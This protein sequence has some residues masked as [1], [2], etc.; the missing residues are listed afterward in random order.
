MYIQLQLFN[1]GYLLT[2]FRDQKVECQDYD[3]TNMVKSPR[4]G[5]FYH[6]T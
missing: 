6:H 3:Q 1:L 2:G 5:L 4:F